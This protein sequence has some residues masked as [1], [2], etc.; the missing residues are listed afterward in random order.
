MPPPGGLTG[1]G[2]AEFIV[3]NKLEQLIPLVQLTSRGHIV[4]IFVGLVV[5]IAASAE[6]HFEREFLG[7]QSV[8]RTVVLVPHLSSDRCHR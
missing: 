1:S 6:A 7:Q 2:E 5:G 4:L 3:S 8:V